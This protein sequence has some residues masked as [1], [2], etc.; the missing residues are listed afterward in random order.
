[1]SPLFLVARSFCFFSPESGFTRRLR[2]EN[3]NRVCPFEKDLVL[4]STLILFAP[5]FQMEYHTPSGPRIPRDE[6]P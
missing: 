4:T 2:C 5:K 3:N 6:Y 1:M